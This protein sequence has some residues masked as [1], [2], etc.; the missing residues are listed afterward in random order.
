[1]TPRWSG[2]AGSVIISLGY[3]N[4]LALAG[5][6]DFR[7]PRFHGGGGSHDRTQQA[8]AQPSGAVRRDRRQ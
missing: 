1:Y 3:V 2:A 6:F 7:R 8:P 5:I 4:V